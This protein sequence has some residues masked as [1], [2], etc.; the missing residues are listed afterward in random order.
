MKLLCLLRFQTIDHWYS[1]ATDSCMLPPGYARFLPL[2]VSFG[3]VIGCFLYKLMSPIN[4]DTLTFF[5]WYGC[6]YAFLPSCWERVCPSVFRARTLSWA[7]VKAGGKD[8][9]E[10]EALSWVSGKGWGEW[11]A[12]WE[13]AVAGRCMGDFN[14]GGQRDVLTEDSKKPKVKIHC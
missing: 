6:L 5:S 14:A 7:V 11:D 8:R 9:N 12:A 13:G 4:S 2:I 1:G 3:K 10:E